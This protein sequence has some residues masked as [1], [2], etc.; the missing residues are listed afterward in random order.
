MQQS[1]KISFGPGNPESC[2]IY[3]DEIFFSGIFLEKMNNNN[4][5]IIIIFF[6][7]VVAFM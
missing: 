5:L 6:W 2:A 3:Y 7:V 4:L 1:N